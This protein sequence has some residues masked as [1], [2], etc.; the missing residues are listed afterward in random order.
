MGDVWFGSEQSSPIIT[1]ERKGLWLAGV[2][3]GEVC[4]TGGLTVTRT[5]GG[6]D[7]SPSQNTL[8]KCLGQRHLQLLC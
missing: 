8:R 5:G 7:F 2:S 4:A 3:D 6:G 1:T